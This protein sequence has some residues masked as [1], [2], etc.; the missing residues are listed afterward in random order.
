MI[1]ASASRANH[2][3]ASLSHLP[4]GG[5]AKLTV[6][7]GGGELFHGCPGR[8]FHR[9]T[10]NARRMGC[11]SPFDVFGTFAAASNDQSII[12]QRI[13]P[14]TF[15]GSSTPPYEII[16]PSPTSI[17]KT[18]GFALRTEPW[19]VSKGALMAAVSWILVELHRNLL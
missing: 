3:A 12:G 16:L 2:I 4:D 5:R 18:L 1:R 11:R 10:R 19:C 14:H 6:R 17:G 7:D 9:N 8:A 13:H 15:S